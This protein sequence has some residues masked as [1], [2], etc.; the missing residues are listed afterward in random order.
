MAQI[1][2]KWIS[3]NTITEAKLNIYNTPTD[4]YFLSWN[5]TKSILEWVE[6]GTALDSHDLKITLSDTTPSFLNTKLLVT[7]NKLTKTINNPGGNETLTLSIGTD[8][9]DKTSDTTDNV[10]EGSTNLYYTNARAD[11]RITLQKGAASGLCPLDASSKIATT[12]LPGLAISTTTPVADI[13]ARD[14]LTSS[15]SGDM[16]IVADATDDP[17]VASGGATYIYDGTS[18]Y[19]TT[20]W[21]RMITPDDS[22]TSVNGSTGVVTLD[23]DDISEGSS[24]LYYTDARARAAIGAG[25]GIS[26]D[27][28]TGII[29]T[30]LDYIETKKV[31]VITLTSTNITNKYVDLTETPA[32]ATAVE[33]NP[34][35]GPAQEYTTD[36]TVITNGSV[37]K[38]LNWSSLGMDGILEAGDKLIVSYTY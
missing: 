14:A 20:G 18:P 10:S 2:G 37:V 32:T 27:N 35:G 31:E 7:T 36:F 26:Y 8:V 33:V 13:T 23:T 19:A 22:V 25:T 6:A 4:G 15:E 9:F 28:I 30:N 3:D 29:S 12:Y 21:L 24:N 16:A 11:A 17:A 38:R 5:G 1:N 34:V